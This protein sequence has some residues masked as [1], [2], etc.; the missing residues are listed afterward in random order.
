MLGKEHA[1]RNMHDDPAK[2]TIV[3]VLY[4]IV[5]AWLSGPQMAKNNCMATKLAHVPNLSLHNYKSR[6]MCKILAQNRFIY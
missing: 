5:N 6:A 3:F 2:E 4:C 1:T